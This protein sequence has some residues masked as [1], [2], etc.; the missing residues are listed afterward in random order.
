MHTYTVT[1]PLAD[2]CHYT[3]AQEAGG[4]GFSQASRSMRIS[5]ARYLLELIAVE[6]LGVIQ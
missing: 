3:A 5:I 4:S 6:T 1:C 2:S